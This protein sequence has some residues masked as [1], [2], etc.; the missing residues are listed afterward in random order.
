MTGLQ[1]SLKQF[2]GL[3]APDPEREARDIDSPHFQARAFY[4]ESL[5][6][7]SLPKLLAKEQSLVSE[8]QSFDSDLQ[9]LVYDNYSKFLGASDTVD[10]LS[11]SISTMTDK[12]NHLRDNLTGV[13]KHSEEIGADLEP[14][15]QK[16]QRLVGI[17]RLLE[18]VEFIS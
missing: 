6:T 3:D 11:E 8:I 12:M 10:S 14:N 9:T 4:E 5:Q 17:S 18:R 15:R 2:Y 13:A 7:D 16:I 1:K